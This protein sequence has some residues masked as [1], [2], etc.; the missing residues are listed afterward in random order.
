MQAD[1]SNQHAV[2]APA[3]GHAKFIFLG[4]AREE[5][6]GV[7]FFVGK[8][9]AQSCSCYLSRTN[10]R[11]KF[12]NIRLRPFAEHE[13]GSLKNVRHALFQHSRWMY[14]E[15]TLEL[16]GPPLRGSSCKRSRCTAAR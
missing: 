7:L 13:A 5:C 10:Q 9:N 1:A 14:A 11:H 8:R 12:G 2:A 6:G 16:P 15:I 3:D 4:Y